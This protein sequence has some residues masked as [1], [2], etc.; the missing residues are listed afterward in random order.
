M[1]STIENETDELSQVTEEILALIENLK[2]NTKKSMMI[3][4]RSILKGITIF[5]EVIKKL[6]PEKIDDGIISMIIS[7]TNIV[8]FRQEEKEQHIDNQVH[9]GIQQCYMMLDI[10]GK[11][12]IRELIKTTTY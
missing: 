1:S 9:Y 6:N 7:Y 5:E 4:E 2:N 10:Y 12:K 11:R 8:L 3:G